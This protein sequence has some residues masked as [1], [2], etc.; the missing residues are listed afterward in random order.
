MKVIVKLYA[1]LGDCLPPGTKGNEVS[2][3]VGEDESINEILG[4]FR[5]PERMTKLVLVNGIYIAPEAR[6][7]RRLADGDHL[8][9][10]PPVAGG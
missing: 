7:T 6:P 5:V 10:W 9:I 2:V 4:R 8:A 1:T 3:E